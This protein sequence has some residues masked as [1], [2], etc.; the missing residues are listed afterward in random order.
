MVPRKAA[1]L[2]SG[3]GAVSLMRTALQKRRMVFEG[4]TATRAVQ[5]SGFLASLVDYVMI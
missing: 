1:P 5:M 2:A 4:D 3:V